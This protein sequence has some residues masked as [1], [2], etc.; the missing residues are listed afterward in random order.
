MGY[1]A[2]ATNKASTVEAFSR[3]RLSADHRHASIQST[4]SR[5][6][7]RHR[8][9]GPTGV[10]TERNAWEVPH[11][12]GSKSRA[13]GVVA[14]VIARCMASPESANPEGWRIALSCTTHSRKCA[15]FAQSIPSEWR[16]ACTSAC[17]LRASVIRRL[18]RPEL[19]AQGLD[20]GCIWCGFRQGL[21]SGLD[22]PPM[23]AKLN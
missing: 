9:G 22:V 20:H 13:W 23:P 15:E 4:G 5:S 17:A 14:L 8:V 12:H 18:H 11:G 6:G 2:P 1:V 7:E 3:L 10:C 16:A 19:L 21:C